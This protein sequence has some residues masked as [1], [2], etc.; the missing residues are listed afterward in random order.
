MADVPNGMM[1]VMVRNGVVNVMAPTYGWYDGRVYVMVA[2]PTYGVVN[3][4]VMNWWWYH[5]GVW[6]NDG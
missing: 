5:G 2:V 1:A 6:M 4:V 3:G